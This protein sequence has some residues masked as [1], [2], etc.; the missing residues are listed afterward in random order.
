MY[1]HPAHKEIA[2]EFEEDEEDPLCG[3]SSSAADDDVTIMMELEVE[4]GE[5]GGDGLFDYY[6][7]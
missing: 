5:E 4:G 7:G 6:F 3:G 1:Y 2:E